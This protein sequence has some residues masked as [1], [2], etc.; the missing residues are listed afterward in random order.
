MDVNGSNL[1][2]PRLEKRLGVQ[3]FVL[4]PASEWSRYSRGSISRRIHALPVG[5]LKSTH[6]FARTTTTSATAA[7]R[8]WCLRGLLFVAPR[9][10]SVIFRIS[11]GCMLGA[12]RVQADHVL[13]IESKGAS[14]SLRD[15]SINCSCGAT[16][17]M[18]GA[19]GKK[20]MQG[21]ARCSGRRPW[22]PGDAELCSELPRTLQRGASNVWFPVVHSSI[23]IPPWL[24]VPSPF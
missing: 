12:A 17:T 20:A 16:R 19:F 4:P 13:K 9:V 11:I 21:I 8:L 14:S 6:S 1:H 2:Q 15:I 10:T 22:L 18:E 7:V 24:K 5:D 3:G 23:S